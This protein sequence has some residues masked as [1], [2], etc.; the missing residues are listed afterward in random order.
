[1]LSDDDT[2]SPAAV[3][4][5]LDKPSS[6]Q[7][8]IDAIR[9]TAVPISIE[10]MHIDAAQYPTDEELLDSQEHLDQLAM[11]EQLALQAAGMPITIDN[12]DI[13]RAA[14]ADAIADSGLHDKESTDLE[15]SQR[16][17]LPDTPLLKAALDKLRPA[18]AIRRGHSMQ[19]TRRQD[20]TECQTDALKIQAA[21]RREARRVALLETGK[22]PEHLKDGRHLRGPHSDNPDFIPP[23]MKLPTDYPE[24]NKPNGLKRLD[25]LK[26]EVARQEALIARANFHYASGSTDKL[27]PHQ[28]TPTQEQRENVRF[29]ASCGMEPSH[30]ARVVRD[31]DGEAISQHILEKVFDVELAEGFADLETKVAS[32]MVRKA[33]MPNLDMAGVT[34]A[35]FILARRAKWVEPKKIEVTGENGGSIKREETRTIDVTDRAAEFLKQLASAK[36][37]SVRDEV[38]VAG[39]G[40]AKA[41]PT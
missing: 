33:T 32:A 18:Q 1:M 37:A 22:I 10:A 40:K 28:F 4:T 26:A 27:Q 2:N 15:L 7:D 20:R 39:A 13:L 25:L 12:D 19:T 16:V 6:L 23:N 30:I 8:T 36:A 34:A 29:L 5:S 14:G 24:D 21:E 38:V 11:E 35:Q 17:Y 9:L 31:L 41:D 3:L